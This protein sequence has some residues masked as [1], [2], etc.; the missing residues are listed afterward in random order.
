VSAHLDALRHVHAV[1][2]GQGVQV[3]VQGKGL[4]HVPAAR[5]FAGRQGV[6]LERGGRPQARQWVGTRRACSTPAGAPP[7]CSTH[8]RLRVRGMV[9][10][11]MRGGRSPP[12]Q[13]VSPHA[14][15]IDPPHAAPGRPGGGLHSVGG[16]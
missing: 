3:V 10:V 5:A 16:G 15:D 4:N 12:W 13:G 14:V 2:D 1:L 9:G 6:L 8:S 7:S 11:E